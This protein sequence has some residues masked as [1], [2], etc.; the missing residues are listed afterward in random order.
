MMKVM[1]HW[2]RF[3]RMVVYAPSLGTFQVRWDSGALS[4]LIQ[5]KMSLLAA[6]GPLGVP[7]NAKRSVILWSSAWRWWGAALLLWTGRAEQGSAR[8]GGGAWGWVPGP[9]GDCWG[10]GQGAEVLSCLLGQGIDCQGIRGAAGLR[11][12]WGAWGERGGGWIPSALWGVLHSRGWWGSSDLCG[13]HQGAIWGLWRSPGAGL[14]PPDVPLPDQREQRTLA[15]AWLPLG[16]RLLRHTGLGSQTV[17]SQQDSPFIY[18]LCFCTQTRI[19]F[20]P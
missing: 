19:N 1:K 15:P 5:L 7:Y 8:L 16:S 14:R 9:W 17:F 20:S 10:L 6:E 11:G 4:T 18:F 3:P 12:L 2:H 13:P